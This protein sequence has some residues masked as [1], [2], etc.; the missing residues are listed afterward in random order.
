MEKAFI[1]QHNSWSWLSLFFS[2]KCTS[3]SETFN[4]NKLNR[5]R[6]K[7]L[8]AYSNKIYVYVIKYLLETN[9]PDIVR[10]PMSLNYLLAATSAATWIEKKESNYVLH[11]TRFNFLYG[12][13]IFLKSQ[14]ALE[15][16]PY[17]I[18]YFPV[19]GHSKSVQPCWKLFLM[20]VG[21]PMC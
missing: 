8:K 12:N 6:I 7:I 18:I 4:S 21:A 16:S 1:I 20:T 9:R 3:S 19:K 14:T 5:K 11:F 15:V 17:N 10:L 2:I 13:P